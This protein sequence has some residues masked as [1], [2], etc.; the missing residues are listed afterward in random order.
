MRVFLA[1]PLIA[2]PIRRLL[3]VR[4]LTRVGPHFSAPTDAVNEK[5]HQRAATLKPGWRGEQ[6]TTTISRRTLNFSGVCGS[7]SK[8]TAAHE[9]HRVVHSRAER[10]GGWIFHIYIC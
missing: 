4:A 3:S 2:Q 6:K 8:C 10:L 5:Q 7:S 1:L 9:L